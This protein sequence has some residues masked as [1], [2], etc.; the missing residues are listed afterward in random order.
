M[1]KSPYQFHNTKEKL[2]AFLPT[3]LYTLSAQTTKALSLRSV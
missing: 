1:E 3:S 2:K